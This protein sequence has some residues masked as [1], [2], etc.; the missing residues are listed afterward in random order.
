MQILQN[1]SLKRYNTFGIE[2]YAK[3]FSSF[4]SVFELQDILQSGF[5][6]PKHLLVL[7]GGSNILFTKNFE[8][9]VLKN[10]IQGIETIH[11]EEKYVYVKAGAGENWHLFVMHCVNKNFSG[12]ENL[13]MIPGNLGA[14]PMQNIGAYG[15][16]LKD[17]FYSLE[18]YSLE[19]KRI[20]TFSLNDCEFGYR[21]SIFK[22]KYKNQFVI[23]N[24]TFKLSKTP[25]FNISYGAI[26]EELKRMQVK[27][28]SLRAVSNAVINIRSSKLPDPAK[29]GNAGSF[30]KNPEIDGQQLN[31]LLKKLSGRS[32]VPFYKI[33]E[34]KFKIPAGWL[35]EQCGWKG[36]RKG[37]A[38]CYEKQALVLVNYGNAGGKEIL[39]LSGEIQ[40]S[41]M[42]KFGIKLETEVNIN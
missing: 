22:K 11:E 28:L 21:D 37:D 14:S 13:S 9:L 15:V 42:K 3:Y 41:V 31:D 6:N 12:V 27:E 24:V 34:D 30:F 5:N 18:A 33:H 2:I 4:N 8:G 23:L 10:E 1:Y 32:D 16:E 35:I 20:T 17:N 26:E 7:G 38:G 36:Y 19:E 29:I 39:T 40:A 25:H